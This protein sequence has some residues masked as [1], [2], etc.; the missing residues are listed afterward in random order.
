[1]E[2]II[3][4]DISQSD[5]FFKHWN[6]SQNCKV[7]S[8]CKNSLCINIEH[9]YISKVDPNF[10]E[11]YLHCSENNCKIWLGKFVGKRPFYAQKDLRNLVY[12]KHGKILKGYYIGLCCENFK[13][14]NIDHMYLCNKLDNIKTKKSKLNFEIAS[15]I[16][17]EKNLSLAKLAEKYNTSKQN[18]S[19]ILNNLTWFDENYIP[20][21]RITQC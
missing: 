12:E 6:I 5:Y 1:M 7:K 10:L 21:S 19:L 17:K 15:R 11:N 16:R 9:L 13:C 3:N 18:I 14:L 2:C 20:K 8:T 4:E